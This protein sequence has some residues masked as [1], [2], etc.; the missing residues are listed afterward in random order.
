M[1]QWTETAVIYDLSNIFK[2]GEIQPIKI[3]QNSPMVK[4][5]T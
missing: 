3:R 5:T 1:F 2:L 4:V